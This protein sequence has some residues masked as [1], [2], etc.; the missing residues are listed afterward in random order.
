MTRSLQLMA[1]RLL[2][3][4]VTRVVKEAT[5]D[6]WK[7][8]LCLLEA[9]GLK[10]WLVNA[11]DV[12]HRPGRPK[13]RPAGRGVAVQGRRAAD[14]PAQLHAATADPAVAGSPVTGSR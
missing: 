4:G 14:D 10:V 5:S 8:P 7:P 1:D 6:Y 2:E 3:L 13:D 12:K 11:K 9:H